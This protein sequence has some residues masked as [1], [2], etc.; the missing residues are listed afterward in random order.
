MLRKFAANPLITPDQL[1]PTHPELEVWRIFNAGATLYN[2]K[3]VLLCRV[4]E[5][6]IPQKG[7]MSTVIMDPDQPGNY[8]IVRIRE[9][10]PD[11]QFH[12]PRGVFYYKKQA[13]LHCISH[14]RLAVSD[15]GRTFTLADKPTMMPEHDYESYGIEDARITRLGSTYY[16]NYSA[17]APYGVTTALARTTDF[18]SFEKLGIIFAPDNKDVSIFPEKVGGKYMALHRPSMKEIG[19]PSIWLAESSDLLQWGPHHFVMGPRPGCWDAERVGGGAAPVRTTRGWLE[20]YHGAD[21]NIRY[22]SAAVLLDGEQP[23]RVIARSRDPILVPQ[24]RY[25]MEGFLPN[26][27]FHNGLVERGDGTLDIYYGGADTTVCGATLDIQA[28]L[29]SLIP[30]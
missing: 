30:A 26:V 14:L 20:I 5:R 27:V 29:D 16:I 18:K 25:E 6:P 19:T 24:E 17:V 4:A 11:L 9:D 22:C 13:M 7:Y 10:D 15:D 8:K 3:T 21:H 28:V 23:W 2:G 12:D 1:K